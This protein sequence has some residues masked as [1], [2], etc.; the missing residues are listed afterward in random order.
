MHWVRAWFNVVPLAVGVELLYAG[1]LPARALS[2]TFDDGYADNAEAG[3]AD[4]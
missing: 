1:K 2:I 4:P 3:R